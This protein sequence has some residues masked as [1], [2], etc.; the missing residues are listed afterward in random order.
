MISFPIFTQPRSFQCGRHRLPPDDRRARPASRPRRNTSGPPARQPVTDWADFSSLISPGLFRLDSDFI[1][2]RLLRNAVFGHGLHVE[3]TGAVANAAH[4][5][6]ELQNGVGTRGELPHML[7][8]AQVN[9]GPGQSR[10]VN[11]ALGRD[12]DAAAG[13]GV[14]EGCPAQALAVARALGL[15]VGFA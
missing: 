14:G 3:A 10:E 2:H 12:N 7:C 1:V 11:V 4:G 13:R 15:D 8:V 6:V 9:V 5:A